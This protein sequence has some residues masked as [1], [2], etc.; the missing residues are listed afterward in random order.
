MRAIALNDADSAHP[1]IE[2]ETEAGRLRGRW[3][4]SEA[5]ARG[6]SVDVE[7]DVAR[8][9]LFADFIVN[10]TGSRDPRA[11]R[12]V[13]QAAFDDGVIVLQVGSSALQ[14]E[15]DDHPQG[16][17]VVG[18]TVDLIADDLEIFPTGV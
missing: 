11:L 17:A 9:R 6:Q 10:P 7:L 8:T 13:I 4:G 12:G 18:K 2:I 3:C 14:I 1:S 5:I 15:L 16:D